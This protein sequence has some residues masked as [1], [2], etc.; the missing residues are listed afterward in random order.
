[1]SKRLDISLETIVSSSACILRKVDWQRL[2]GIFKRADPTTG[3]V[4]S[5]PVALMMGGYG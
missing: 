3:D 2:T 5:S 1:M 4:E